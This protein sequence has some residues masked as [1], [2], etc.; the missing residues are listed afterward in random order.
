[1]AVAGGATGGDQRMWEEGKAMKKIKWVWVAA[2]LICAA[3]LPCSRAY[4]AGG[5]IT[6]T[7]SA[8]PLKCKSIVWVEASRQYMVETVEGVTLS[9]PKTAVT[10]MSVDKPAGFDDAV[11]LVEARQFAQAIPSL[12]RIAADYRMLVWDVQAKKLLLRCYLGDNNTAKVMVTVEE[13]L[14]T[15]SRAEMPADLMTSYWKALRASNRG[16]TLGAE[17]QSAIASGSADMAAAAYLLR[18]DVNRDTGR[19]SEA[20]SDYLKVAQLFQ[21]VKGTRPEALFKAAELLE[22]IKDPRAED[23]R[24]QLREEFKD[25]E[26][27][28]K[29]APPK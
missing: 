4:A 7:G 6:R 11:K 12:E 1:M 16:E 20:L 28:A 22:D 3:G 26:F 13:M 14:K 10:R 5:V 8:T 24:K 15:T 18:G 21:Q 2:A 19:K 17:L 29:L 25:N 27:T 9:V 23:L